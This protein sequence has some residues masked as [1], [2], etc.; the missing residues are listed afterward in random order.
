MVQNIQYTILLNFYCIQFNF[1]NFIARRNK[2]LFPVEI[3]I[4]I[5]QKLFEVSL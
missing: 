4:C 5:A 1:T 2:V 3:V